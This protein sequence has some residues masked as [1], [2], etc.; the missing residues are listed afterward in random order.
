L[1]I[2]GCE[3]ISYYSQAVGGHLALM[4]AARPVADWLADPRT[5]P[6]LRTRLERAQRMREFAVRELAL[7]DN[8]SYRSYAELGRSF[9]VWNVVATPAL[10]VEPLPQ[11]F[12]F[13]GCV[14]YRGFFTEARAEHHAQRLAES[15]N[16]VFV[17]G[18]LAYSTLGWFDDPLLSTFIHDP[19][20]QLARLLFHELAHQVAYAKGDATFNESF[21]AVVEE[22]GVRR[23]LAAEGRPGEA[24]AFRA[25][26]ARRREFAARVQQMRERLAEIYKKD[27]SREEKLAQKRLAFE[28]LRADYPRLVPAQLNNAF[29]ASVAIYTQ[30]VPEFERLLAESGTLEKFYER[31][32]ALAASARSSRD[33]S[34]APR[35]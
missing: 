19:D 28:Q 34:S 31:V 3:S 18:V 8:G 24:E 27:I 10:A 1:L 23:W 9:A 35:Q 14:G 2:S 4:G 5:P 22:E 20:W 6:E 21:A 30:R 7:P 33:P 17:G 13:A 26:Q 25:F 12:P 11:C 15:G 29:L 16:D 32:R